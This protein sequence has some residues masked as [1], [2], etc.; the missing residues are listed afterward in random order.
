MQGEESTAEDLP[1]SDVFENPEINRIVSLPADAYDL[2]QEQNLGHVAKNTKRTQ[3]TRAKQANKKAKIKNEPKSLGK[4]P[5]KPAT[6]NKQPASQRA[7]G[8]QRKTYH[9]EAGPSRPAATGKRRRLS[10]PEESLENGNSD[11]DDEYEKPGGYQYANG[12]GIIASRP[13]LNRRVPSEYPNNGAGPSQPA[14][15]RKPAAHA[16]ALPKFNLSAFR[17]P[18]AAVEGLAGQLYS[19]RLMNFM[20]HENLEIK[21][22]PHVNVITGP[23]GSGKSAILQALQCCLGVKATQTGRFRA[24]RE[25]IKHG[26]HHA[27]VQVT[28]WNTG[29]DA[30]MAEYFGPQITIERRFTPKTSVV[31]IKDA[32]GNKRLTGKEELNKCLEGLSIN[33][34]N[35]AVVLTQDQAR[36]FAGDRGDNE[37]Y[38][39]F[40]QATHFDITIQNLTKSNHHIAEHE[41]VLEEHEKHVAKVV[42]RINELK[43]QLEQLREIDNWRRDITTLTQTLAWQI[44][45]DLEANIQRL[46]RSVEDEG[47]NRVRTARL[48][49]DDHVKHVQHIEAQLKKE[50]RC[51]FCCEYIKF[52]LVV[53]S[54]R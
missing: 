34:S 35:P 11:E 15:G 25:F 8:V 5:S 51:L 46:E 32:L 43:Q 36:C 12:N 29:R 18:T 41:A 10:S 23:N 50:V 52:L 30:Y 22:L 1:W 9:D 7:N 19:V 6:K 42:A 28:V 13:S 44:V 27:R 53:Y 33:A 54:Y 16:T 49:L 2:V 26:E 21:F 17:M 20:C 4:Q 37:K 40:V 39:I 14:R 31:E 47:P 45:Y 38:D 3:T 48:Q 24:L